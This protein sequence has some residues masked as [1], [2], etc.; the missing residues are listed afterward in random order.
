MTVLE[1]FEELFSR[2]CYA[3][4]QTR[5]MLRAR[6]LAFGIVNC[7]GRRTVTGFLTSC[8]KLFEDWSADYRIFQ[9]DRMDV[10][11]IFDVVRKE[12]LGRLSSQGPI[13]AHMDDTLLKKTGKKVSGTAWRRDPLGPPFHT[14]FIWGQRF[15]QISVS[16]P[17]DQGPSSARSVPV[18]MFHA[19]TIKKPR[20]SDD[21]GVWDE[22]KEKQKQAK[23]SRQGVERIKVLRNKLDLDGAVN[24]PLVMSV[25]GSYSNETVLKNLPPRTTL[26]GRIRKDTQ[27]NEL[28]G[29]NNVKGR[30]RIYG[31]ELPTPEQI[32][33][34]KDYP[35]IQVAA[36]AAGKKHDFNVKIV[37]D[38]RWRK[39]G[40]QNLQLV[41]IRPL[42]YRL[43][44]NSKLLYRRPAYLICTDTNMEIGKLLQ[45]YLWRWG[46]EVN[47]REE[48]TLL[49]CG[50]AQVRTQ[51]AI[52]KV[53]AF[54]TA[55]YAMIQLAADKINK[56]RQACRLPRAKW[57]PNKSNSK[58]TT[59]DVINDLKSQAWAKSMNINFTNFVNLQNNI[60][61][62]KNRP[63]VPLAAYL[64]NRK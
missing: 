14:N 12:L 62:A 11:K 56:N 51:S 24:R 26:I 49:G 45:A 18:D 2:S 28:P 16:L 54:I 59:G 25:D 40:K 5:T 1:A 29:T 30:K 44:K 21:K 9:Q 19:P 46:I 37:R 13:Y 10:T 48:K 60:R 38:I 63:H 50:Q 15:I 43:T 55:I 57:Y 39:A 3:F 33:Q 32:R 4:K 35:W 17:I 36:Y 22:Y 64:Y 20:S 23:L 61:S 27:L 31:T 47:F 34:S 41:V 52:E 58:Y 53:P 6:E 8:G 7:V 42:S